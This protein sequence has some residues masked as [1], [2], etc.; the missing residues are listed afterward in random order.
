MATKVASL[1][2]DPDTKVALA[3]FVSEVEA[4]R[5]AVAALK[6]DH[7]T[8]VAK[9]NLDAGVTDVNYAVSTAATLS[10]VVSV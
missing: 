7:N 6:A 2:L 1:K 9:L 3:D 4:L 8:L 10:A 5:T